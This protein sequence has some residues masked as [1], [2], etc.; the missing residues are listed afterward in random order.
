[1]AYSE[2][3]LYL[4][5]QQRKKA[6]E[7]QKAV[8]AEKVEEEKRQLQKTKESILEQLRAEEKAEKEQKHITFRSS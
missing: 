5:E 4:E 7:L 1:M 6:D 2:Y 8:E 3:K